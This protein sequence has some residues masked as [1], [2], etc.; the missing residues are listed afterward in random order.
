MVYG[1][2]SHGLLVQ[3]YIGMITLYNRRWVV[4]LSISTSYGT[5][6]PLGVHPTRI[7]TSIHKKIYSKVIILKYMQNCK[8]P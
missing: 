3:E 6:A 4:K 2:R 8:S 5:A 7:S 1:W